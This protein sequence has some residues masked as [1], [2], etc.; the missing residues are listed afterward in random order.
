MPDLVARIEQDA[1]RWDNDGK[2]REIVIEDRA[3][4]IGAYQTLMATGSAR[5]C[6]A[7]RAFNPTSSK[8]ERFSNAGVWVANHSVMLPAPSEAVRW[9]HAFEAEVFEESEFLD[10]RDAV[11][12]LILFYEHILAEGFRARGERRAP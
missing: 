11:A 9:L 1:V 5:L 6:A 12:Q 3:S 10:Q 7:L 2:L 4:G 8:D